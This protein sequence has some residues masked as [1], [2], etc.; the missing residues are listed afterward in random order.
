MTI[1][2]NN[3]DGEAEGVFE[4]TPLL[5]SESPAAIVSKVPADSAGMRDAI[6]AFDGEKESLGVR[7]EVLLPSQRPDWV[8]TA[9][10]S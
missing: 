4:L 8:T 2:G 6:N 1:T 9:R 7:D 10:A 5:S 3:P